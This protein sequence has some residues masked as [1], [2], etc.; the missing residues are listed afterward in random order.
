MDTQIKTNGYDEQRQVFRDRI[1]DTSRAIVCGYEISSN[2]T[3]PLPV[4][5]AYLRARNNLNVNEV[6]E[7]LDRN[8]PQEEIDCLYEETI[9]VHNWGRDIYWRAIGEVSQHCFDDS[10]RQD[11]SYLDQFKLFLI[12]RLAREKT[13]EIESKVNGGESQARFQGIKRISD[14]EEV[15]PLQLFET[16][17][18]DYDPEMLRFYPGKIVD[19]GYRG[20]VD[21]LA[22]RD[23]YEAMSKKQSLEERALLYR[24]T[25][26]S[27]QDRSLA[28]WEAMHYVNSFCHARAERQGTLVEELDRLRQRKD[29]SS[30]KFEKLEKRHLDYFIDSHTSNPAEEINMKIIRQIE[31]IALKISGDKKQSAKKLK[32]EEQGEL[33]E[34]LAKAISL[35]V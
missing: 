30:E 18:K 3:L 25:K 9:R 14:R 19:L 35:E 8:A 24:K 10:A 11:V 4:Q 2:E 13:I 27:H 28:F 17:S 33:F 29:Y 12:L 15:Y 20:A 34:L 6:L 23:C 26:K 16:L 31:R 21:T 7:A 5:L 1:L 32:P 22:M